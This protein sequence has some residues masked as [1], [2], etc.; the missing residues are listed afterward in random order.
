M[1]VVPDTDDVGVGSIIFFPQGQYRASEGNNIG[2]VRYHEGVITK[3]D[4]LS[5]GTVLVNGHH[6]RGE[7]D[8]KFCRYKDYK[9][10]FNEIPLNSIRLAASALDTMQ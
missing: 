1:D 7:D 6:T 3:V 10:K 4:I 5:E 8:G 9:Y 2:G